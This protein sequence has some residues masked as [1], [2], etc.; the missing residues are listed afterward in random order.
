MPPPD[1]PPASKSKSKKSLA[2]TLI[3]GAAALTYVAITYRSVSAQAV[4]DE[5]RPADV[6]IVFGAAEYAGRPSPAF[7]ARLDHALDIY[8]QGVAP[9]I[10]TTGGKG[11][12]KFTEG[13]VGRDYLVAAGVPDAKVI[14]ETQSGDTSESAQRVATI[15]RA[16]NMTTCV[17]VSDGYHIYRIKR[18]MMNQG[19]E[20]YG[21]PRLGGNKTP[22]I[23]LREVASITL[24]RLH[25][26]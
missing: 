15:M 6:I 3:I 9:F 12:V 22:L 19:V 20:T 11:D 4:K 2:A 16:N 25:I 1:F 14:A 13:G 23:F 24:W 26:T 10:I 17:A 7:R 8:R 5:A 18:M 21:S